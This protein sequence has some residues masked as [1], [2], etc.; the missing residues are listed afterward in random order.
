MRKHGISKDPLRFRE[1]YCQEIEMSLYDTEEYKTKIVKRLTDTP[2]PFV[3]LSSIS[4][5]QSKWN[6]MV[7]MYCQ[8][9]ETTLQEQTSHRSLVGQTRLV[10]LPFETLA[11]GLADFDRLRIHGVPVI[12]KATQ[13]RGFTWVLRVNERVISSVAHCARTYMDTIHHH[14]NEADFDF[15]KSLLVIQTRLALG[16]LATDMDGLPMLWNTEQPA[17]HEIIE[18]SCV[19]MWVHGE[20]T[21]FLTQGEWDEMKLAVCMGQHNRLGVDSYLSSLDS[22]CLRLVLN[23]CETGK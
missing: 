18:S 22:D 6:A 3:P 16:T 12:L 19:R 14:V 4:H 17:L 15:L 21:Q 20:I 1:Q 10:W 11:F 9:V 8:L 7:D 5:F 13:G 23:T 2:A